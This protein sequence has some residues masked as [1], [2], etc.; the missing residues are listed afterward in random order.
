MSDCALQEANAQGDWGNSKMAHLVQVV[1]L[2]I[3][4]GFSIRADWLTLKSDAEPVCIAMRTRSPL[5]MSVPMASRT[6]CSHGNG[7]RALQC[8][9]PEAASLE[10][11]MLLQSEAASSPAARA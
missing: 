6:S 8:F 4:L 10:T 7:I 5:K 11:I 2:F 9:C 1:M 3:K